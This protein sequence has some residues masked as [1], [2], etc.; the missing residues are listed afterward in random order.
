M[1]EINGTMDKYEDEAEGEENIDEIVRAEDDG[2]DY[3]QVH[4]TRESGLASEDGTADPVGG[5][6]PFTNPPSTLPDSVITDPFSALQHNHIPDPPIER[7][8]NSSYR[9]GYTFAA[10]SSYLSSEDDF[11]QENHR[12][13]LPNNLTSD[14]D[15]HID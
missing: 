9:P 5:A 12:Q 15:P 2:L 8:H 10:P 4:G 1:K 6:T 14:T 7:P 13:E 3:S 11:D